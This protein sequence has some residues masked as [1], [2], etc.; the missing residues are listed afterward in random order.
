MN[1]MYFGINMQSNMPIVMLDAERPLGPTQFR[2]YKN[3]KIPK[4]DSATKSISLLL[5]WFST[6]KR[7][8]IYRIL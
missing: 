8:T 6:P 5:P 3:G 4:H 2:K 1:N 7:N